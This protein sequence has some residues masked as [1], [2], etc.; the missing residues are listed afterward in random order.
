M[1]WNG[2]IR[3][4]TVSYLKLAIYASLKIQNEKNTLNNISK[5]QKFVVF[6]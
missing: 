3:S 6:I 1:K 5:R 4:I 2:T